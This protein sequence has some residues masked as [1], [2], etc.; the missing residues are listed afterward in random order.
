MDCLAM[1]APN[2]HERNCDK[3]A[4]SQEDFSIYP[5]Q[6]ISLFSKSEELYSLMEDSCTM[7]DFPLS[8]WTR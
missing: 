4:S 7:T 6:S 1:S 2:C 8:S 5:G 3:N